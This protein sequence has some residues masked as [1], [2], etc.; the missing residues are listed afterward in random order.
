[1]SDWAHRSY[2]NRT[3]LVIIRHAESNNNVLYDII[4]S[5]LGNDIPDSIVEA[6]E[7]KRRDSD[8]TLSVKGFVQAQSLGEFFKDGGYTNSTNCNDST[9]NDWIILSSP[10]KRCCLTAQEISKTLGDKKVIVLP[11]LYEFGGCY[12]HC[13][14]ENGVYQNK[15]KGFYGRTAEEI[16]AQHKNF[17]CYNFDNDKKGWYHG[18][19]AET[20]NEFRERCKKV[21]DWIWSLHDTEFTSRRIGNETPLGF[22]NIILVGHGLLNSNLIAHLM[23]CEDDDRYIVTHNNTGVSKLELY[24]IKEKGNKRVAAVKG[25]NLVNHIGSDLLTGDH[26]ISDHWIQEILH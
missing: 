10:M 14:D 13:Y 15:T 4:R 19:E 7:A 23:G 5:E 3:Q 11:N 2:D 21:V 9:I 24:C 16:E 25:V 8:C 22:K 6:E 20:I 1:M 18:N 26:V 17:K 12:D